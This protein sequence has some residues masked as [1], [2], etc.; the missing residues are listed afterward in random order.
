MLGSIVSENTLLNLNTDSI[1]AHDPLFFPTISTIDSWW[2]LFRPGTIFD[3][4][5]PIFEERGRYEPR[6]ILDLLLYGSVHV[7]GFVRNRKLPFVTMKPSCFRCVGRRGTP[8]DIEAVVI[9]LG[10]NTS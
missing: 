8:N 1:Q 7:L 6:F 4:V 9:W 5:D 2:L 10:V 3:L